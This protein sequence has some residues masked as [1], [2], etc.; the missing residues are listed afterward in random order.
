MSFKSG[1]ISGIRIKKLTSHNDQ[2]GMLMELY[3]GD[4]M[5]ANL[6]PAMSYLSYTRPGIAR[7]PHEHTY[8]TD[9][10]C[11]VGPGQFRVMLWDNRQESPSYRHYQ[12]IDAGQSQPIQLIVPPGV[13]HG[14]RNISEVDGMVL[15]FPDRLYAGENK[16]GKVDEIRHEDQQDCFY[17]HFQEAG[18]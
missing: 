15:N 2:R 1:K 3:R 12:V 7:G 13:V 6:Y 17:R 10:F 4:E 18:Q 9:I 11:F 16:Q 8:Q 14:Y 5:P